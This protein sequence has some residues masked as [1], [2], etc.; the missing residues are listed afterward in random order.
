MYYELFNEV[1]ETNENKICIFE[2]G[3]F[4]VVLNEQAIYL[5]ELLGL[6]KVC[7]APEICKV[8]FP[9]ASLSK[10]MKML[11]NLGIYFVVL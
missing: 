5:S 8:G 10:Y 3:T 1:F 4:Y 7:F 2:I 6:K 9:I 11:T